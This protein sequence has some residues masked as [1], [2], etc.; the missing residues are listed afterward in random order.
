MIGSLLF[1]Q[2]SAR[3]SSLSACVRDCS[4]RRS[5]TVRACAVWA[6]ET[7]K[8]IAAPSTT[9]IASIA[10]VVVAVLLVRLLFAST[11]QF[12]VKICIKKFRQKVKNQVLD[13]III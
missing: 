4:A 9:V 1:Q 8:I 12:T 3:A 2:V 10:V 5:C 6:K 13:I 11:S 7:V